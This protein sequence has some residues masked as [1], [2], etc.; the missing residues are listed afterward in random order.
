MGPTT[1]PPFPNF[2]VV[3]E[4]V[5]KG[6]IP[7]GGNL[8]PLIDIDLGWSDSASSAFLVSVLHAEAVYPRGPGVDLQGPSVYTNECPRHRVRPQWQLPCQD[9]GPLDAQ[10]PPPVAL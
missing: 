2:I 8:A 7:K 3:P 9:F 1:N 6:F 10:G 4:P 5:V